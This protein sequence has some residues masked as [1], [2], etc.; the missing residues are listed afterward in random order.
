M[1]FIFCGGKPFNFF[2]FLI[3]LQDYDTN[4]HVYMDHNNE[5]NHDNSL[6]LDIKKPALW[7]V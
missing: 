5:A 4:V 3:S 7:Q 6:F 2:V 1:I